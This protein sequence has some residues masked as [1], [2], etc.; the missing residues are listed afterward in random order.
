MI[1]GEHVDVSVFQ[2]PKKGNYECGDSY[3]YIE[4]E[5]EFL[6]VIADGLGSG[7]IAK[8]S[9]QVVIDIIKSQVQ[10]PVEEIVRVCNGELAGK[11]GVV[12][13][14]LKIN[15]HNNIASFSS[16]GNIG[17]MVLEEG[18]K[19]KR[20]IPNAGYLGSFNRKCKVMT[21]QLRK[22]T[23]LIMF[24]DGVQDKELSQRFFIDSNVETI[25]DTYRQ[26]TDKIR[27]DDTT[28]IAMR[29]KK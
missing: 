2:E 29:F 17:I 4:L 15:F 7:E 27:H 13:G 10:A 5:N 16:I 18:K 12:L 24:S 20:N 8:E 9:S 21:Y 1:S 6:C 25:I 26:T 28:L 14:I 23:N 19:K 3:F 22:N 11:R